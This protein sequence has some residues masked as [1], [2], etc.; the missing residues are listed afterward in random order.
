MESVFRMRENEIQTNSDS[1][2]LEITETEVLDTGSE[3]AFLSILTHFLF[4]RI[5]PLS[6][7]HLVWTSILP[8]LL[9]VAQF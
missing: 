5:H 7:Y 3:R 9:I 6:K 4:Y 8:M 2:M 1:L